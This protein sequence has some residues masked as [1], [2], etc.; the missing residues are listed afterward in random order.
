[1]K[2]GVVSDT[3]NH[4]ANVARI[5]E[6]FN[7][8]GVDRVIHTGDITQAATLEL[9]ARLDAPLA[10]VYGNNDA[11]ERAS[12]EAAAAHWRIELADPPL[13]LHLAERRIVVVHDPR[14]LGGRADDH[15]VA[16]HGH[17]HRHVEER[18]G[19]GRLVFNPGECAGHLPGWNAVGIVDLATL[20]T[21]LLR[22]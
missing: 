4:L 9:L 16:L 10:G 3:H 18:R 1:M 21:E 11:G 8:A 12:L 20:E 13:V 17:T 7:R 5:V 2:L 6:L 14:D 19:D 15:D 22:F